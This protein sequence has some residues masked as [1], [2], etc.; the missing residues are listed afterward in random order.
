MNTLREVAFI[1]IES[2]VKDYANT[3]PCFGLIELQ[4]GPMATRSTQ[5]TRDLMSAVSPLIHDAVSTLP[6]EEDRTIASKEIFVHY[7][8][9]CLHKAEEIFNIAYSDALSM[10]IVEANGVMDEALVA[11]LDAKMIAL[12]EERKA[13]GLASYS[14]MTYGIFSDYVLN[15]KHKTMSVVDYLA[16]LDEAASAKAATKEENHA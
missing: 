6:T 9:A 15:D 3:L 2:L 8:Y 7:F 13:K 10:C 14:D 11:R 12:D 16:E 5:A 4:G 1:A